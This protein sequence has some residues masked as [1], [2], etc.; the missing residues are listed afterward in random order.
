MEELSKADKRELR[1]LGDRVWDAD[2]ARTLKILDDEFVKWR[3]G[4]LGHGA[5]LDAIHQFHQKDARQLWGRYQ[6]N[7]AGW[8]VEIG[9]MQG[10][11]TLDDVPLRL[12]A[13]FAHLPRLLDDPE[14]SAP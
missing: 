10:L 1:E 7:A 8:A 13:R 5:L 2:A 4:E 9:L 14:D 12:R 6:S 11:I 3:A